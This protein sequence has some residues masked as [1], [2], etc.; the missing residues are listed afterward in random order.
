M[1]FGIFAIYLALAATLFSTWYYMKVGN[2]GRSGNLVNHKHLNQVAYNR[3]FARQGFY[4]SAV[5]VVIASLYLLY[6][7]FTHK[8]QVAYVY[9]YSSLDLSFGYLLSAFWAG[10]EKVL[11]CISDR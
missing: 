3:K 1:K 9:R 2:I 5:L 8:F 4:I 6:L 7:I 11:S 10:Q